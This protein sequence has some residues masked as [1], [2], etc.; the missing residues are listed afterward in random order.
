M[1]G[2]RRYFVQ[3]RHWVLQLLMHLLPY[4]IAYCI[5]W[6]ELNYRNWIS[7][8]KTYPPTGI[9]GSPADKKQRTDAFGS[10]VIPPKPPK[11]FLRLVWEALQDVTLIILIIAAI[12]SLALSFYSP[13]D[14]AS[15]GKISKSSR[16]LEHR[17]SL[18]ASTPFHCQWIYRVRSD[19]H[20]CSL[21]WV[22]CS[23]RS[24]VRT[25]L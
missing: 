21:E 8:C 25:E 7:W 11:T 12:I 15:L 18:Q 19:Q 5:M 20:R 24:C 4:D 14:D 6:K 22:P 10:N 23:L 2:V 9:S 13:E 17:I 3:L 1:T 16:F